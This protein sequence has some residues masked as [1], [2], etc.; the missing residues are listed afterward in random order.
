MA[1]NENGSSLFM[2]DIPLGYRTLFDLVN[3]MLVVLD[4]RGRV[5][6]INPK[7]CRMLGYK[8]EE[9]VSRDWFSNFL[10]NDQRAKTK[11]VFINMM[12][13]RG[14]PYETFENSILT[15]SGEERSILWNNSYLKDVKGQIRFTLSSGSDI[16]EFRKPHHCGMLAMDL[17]G[18]ILDVNKKGV[19][20]LGL[21]KSRILKMQAFDFCALSDFPAIKKA[22]AEARK[23]GFVSQEAKLIGKGDKPIA[24][25]ISISCLNLGG[26]VL[27][28]CF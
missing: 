26:K 6:M 4:H 24:C 18:N 2:E 27:I 19:E 13:G 3:V 28:A 16:S 25:Q 8:M 21:P 1:K 15:K 7:G 12:K 10:P 11:R 5:A 9:I 23:S 20:K 14:K 22:L 17:K